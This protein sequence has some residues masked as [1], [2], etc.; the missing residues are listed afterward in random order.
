MPAYENYEI[1]H[2]FLLTKIT[3][4]N[5]QSCSFAIFIMN[6]LFPN[7]VFIIYSKDSCIKKQTKT[8][9]KTEIFMHSTII[10]I[11]SVRL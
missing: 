2:L 1:T 6:D 7:L 10:Q 11:F 4:R 5:E 9:K 3:F 8:S